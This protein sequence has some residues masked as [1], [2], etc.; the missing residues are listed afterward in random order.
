MTVCFLPG[1]L[2]TIGIGFTFYK[3][4]NSNTLSMLAI[5]NLFSKLLSSSELP[6]SW[7]VLRHAPP[8]SFLWEGSY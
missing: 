7:V 1:G 6:L 8:Y 5:P 2:L 4:F 3:A